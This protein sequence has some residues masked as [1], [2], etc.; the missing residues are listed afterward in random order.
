MSISKLLHRA[1]VRDP[2]KADEAPI[3]I[4]V[5]M[6]NANATLLKMYFDFYS[7][8]QTDIKMSK[9]CM[10]INKVNHIHS[11][12]R[13][14]HHTRQLSVEKMYNYYKLL[15]FILCIP[16]NA[17]SVADKDVSAEDERAVVNK[18]MN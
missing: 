18:G 11:S 13:T 16:E 5:Q 4:V 14:I 10:I 1:T 17:I 3:Y 9:H 12:D 7:E 8:S 15:L 6:E 2:V